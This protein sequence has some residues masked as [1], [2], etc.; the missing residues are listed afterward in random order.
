MNG[1]GFKHVQ[2]LAKKVIYGRTDYSPANKRVLQAMGNHMI[3]GLVVGRSPIYQATKLALNA[4]SLGHMD[5]EMK[6]EPYDKLFHL[7]LYI[8]L[9]SGKT[10]CMEKLENLKLS[11]GKQPPS[12]AETKT[13]SPVPHGTTLQEFLNKTQQRMGAKF[14]PYSAFHNNCQDLI[15]NALHANGITN[16]EYD[17]F[18]KQETTRKLFTPLLNQSSKLI[19]DLGDRVDI[20]K[21][22]G[23]L[24]HVH[25]FVNVKGGMQTND[26]VYDSDETQ[27]ERYISPEA[28]RK[29]ELDLKLQ[30]FIRIK[31]LLLNDRT[32]RPELTQEERDAEINRCT[33]QIAL[34]LR[35]IERLNNEIIEMGMQMQHEEG[36][37]FKYSRHVHHFQC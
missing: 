31:A 6:K 37:G 26:E 2:Q 20:L 36:N 10:L 13:V 18:I 28:E 29:K 23:K 4:V 32:Y 25:H 19:T 5:A 30:N 17:S 35:K 14:F 22:G 7:A 24:R 1:T 34:G 8:T 27:V 16:P 12:N 9:D 3:T 11:P 21:Q 33:Q 15:L